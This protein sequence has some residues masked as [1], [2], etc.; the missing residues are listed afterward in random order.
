MNEIPPIACH[1]QTLPMSPNPQGVAYYMSCTS[2]IFQQLINR[3][4]N[5]H[6]LSHV[7]LINMVSYVPRDEGPVLI[8][9]DDQCRS[10]GLV[11]AQCRPSVGLVQDQCRT[12]GL[13]SQSR[14]KWIN[15]QTSEVLYHPYITS[16][17][18]ISFFLSFLL[19][20]SLFLFYYIFFLIIIFFLASLSSSHSFFFI[21][22]FFLFSLLS[23]FF[24]F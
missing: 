2:S 18:Y 14:W 24:F 6:V 5:K 7:Q 21:L 1:P 15:N 16:L 11:Q 20:I 3:R 9:C 19:P 22:Y 13:L 17:L 4:T 10:V 8:T 23:F 12:E